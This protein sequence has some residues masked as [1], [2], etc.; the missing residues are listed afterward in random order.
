[1]FRVSIALL[2]LVLLLGAG[3]GPSA[4]LNPPKTPIP[5]TYFGLHMHRAVTKTEWP[6]VPFGSWRLW[7]T[8]VTWQ[9]LEP[10]RG[11]WN[12]AQLDK[13]IA[14]A[15]SHHVEPIVPLA[16]SPTWASA[17]PS[18]P[19]SHAPGGAAEPRD[20]EDWR[21]FV[22]TVATRYKGRAHQYEIWNEPNVPK[23]YSGSVD[24][25]VQVTREAYTVLHNID[26]QAVVVSPSYAG[27][28]GLDG[29][30]QFLAKG[31]GNYVD[32]V[33][34]HFYVDKQP[35]EKMAEVIAQAKAVL[36]RNGVNKPLWDTEAG[37]AHPKPFPIELAPAYVSRA[38][39]LNWAAGVERFYW[40]AWDNHEW[41]TLEMVERDEATM[42]PAAT[43]YGTTAQWLIGAVMNSCSSDASHVWTCS[44]TRDSVP[45]WIVW[46]ESGEG[47]FTIPSSWNVHQALSLLGDT[48]NVHSTGQLSVGPSPQLL[49]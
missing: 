19:S 2:A 1:M 8:H 4:V 3:A 40:Y 7:D 39:I 46:K 26:P 41:V 44:L 24:A 48:T 30:N 49:R 17:R 18:E 38:Y 13:E 28:D 25:L 5:I 15:E 35:P 47:Q 27:A 6:S 14:L 34:H 43:A 31:G 21:T 42:K 29:L 33:G 12:F 11:Q 36:A 16:L 22:R 32:V 23:F 9:D 20:M 45:N 10:A 37:W